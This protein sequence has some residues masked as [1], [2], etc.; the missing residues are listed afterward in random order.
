MKI[1]DI[2]KLAAVAFAKSPRAKS[3]HAGLVRYRTDGAIYAYND[4]MVVKWYSDDP[5]VVF[6]MDES[7]YKA[8]VQGRKAHEA[9][10]S[11]EIERACD[12]DRSIRVPSHEAITHAL[13]ADLSDKF[14]PRY[15]AVFLKALATWAEHLALYIHAPS[16]RPGHFGLEKADGTFVARAFI[17]P[18]RTN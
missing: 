17:A 15:D 4:Y 13:Y 5:T 2:K 8:L 14:P 16:Q 3:R 1:A 12:D 6:S 18:C 7:R 9:V 11:D 10:T